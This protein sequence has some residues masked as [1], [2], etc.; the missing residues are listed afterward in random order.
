MAPDDFAL[1]G[2][3]RIQRKYYVCVCV[4]TQTHYNLFLWL[5]IN[6]IWLLLVTTF[7]IPFVQRTLNSVANSWWHVMT[8]DINGSHTLFCSSFG[9]VVLENEYII[10]HESLCLSIKQVV[11]SVFK[12]ILTCFILQSSLSLFGRWNDPKHFP[13][14]DTFNFQGAVSL[15]WT[16]LCNQ[17]AGSRRLSNERVH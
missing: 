1:S 17:G 13:L 12:W 15:Y 4:C 2:L 9:E 6:I 3:C 16:W 11:T 7:I 10:A 5:W 14:I 8:Q